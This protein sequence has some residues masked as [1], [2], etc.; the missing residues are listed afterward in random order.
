MTKQ[1]YSQYIKSGALI[2]A[3]AVLPFGSSAI[4]AAT[5]KHITVSAEQIDQ[6]KL[7]KANTKGTFSHSSMLPVYASG[8][9]QEINQSLSFDGQE[10]SPVFFLAPNSDQ[11]QLT[12][13]DPNG[14]KVHD[15]TQ[16]KSHKLAAQNVQIGEQTFKGKQLMLQSP[17]TGT[18]QAKLTRDASTQT[19]TQDLTDANAKPEGYL[20]FKGDPKYKLYSF[21][22]E[23]LTTQDKK[24]GL[25]AY[26]IN[27]GNEASDRSLMLQK[28]PLSNS[29]TKA[30][31]TITTPNKQ[32]L[33][34]T[35][36]DNGINGDKIAG[37]GQFSGQVPT[38]DVGV[39]ISQVQVNGIR[40]DGIQFTRTSNDLYRIEAPAYRLTNTPAQLKSVSRTSTLVS[41][42]VE[43]IGA[44]SSV[45]MATEIWGTNAQGKMQAA[46]WIGGVVSPTTDAE[47][48]RLE[49]AFDYRWLQ[50]KDL[51]APYAL[52]S[53]RLQTTDTNVPIAQL[54]NLPL[55]AS[56]SLS[57]VSNQLLRS[58]KE[59]PA[60]GN[61]I[62]I[63]QDML[64][65]NGPTLSLSDISLQGTGSKLLLVHGYCSGNV[66]NT[67]NFTNSAEFQDYNQN[68]SHEAFALNILNFGSPYASYGIVAHSQG[69]AAAVHLYTR[70]WS[71]LDFAS[72]GRLIQSVG[73][74]YRGTALAGSLAA[75]GEIFGIGCGTNTDLTYTGAA[76]WLSTIPSWARAEVDYYTTSFTDVWWR[77]DYCHLGSDLLLDDPDDGTTEKWAGQLSGAVNKGHKTGWCHTT[78]MRDTAQY[79]DSSRNSSMNSRAAR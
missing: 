66:W 16:S 18:W 13:T 72:G 7:P 37:D 55:H 36:N 5:P 76:N 39:Y 12:L 10:D 58:I 62:A 52:R 23:N 56:L 53:V 30:V 61:D 45:Y 75:L 9:T 31:A 54:D 51:N 20:F 22:D 32:Q 4:L 24:I 73:T 68:R 59:K 50:R 69:G 35:L 77:Y 60:Q 19:S 57:N 44:T 79:K 14:S 34:V 8:T 43:K 67:G 15:G 65:G 48:T 74:P 33:H 71:G 29:I 17:S 40:P 26:V 11:W 38:S 25:V 21:I 1:L 63:T 28:R 49:L 70:Y 47:N 78:G 46:A 41:V 27:S 2:T 6:Q 64:M 3:M 42:P